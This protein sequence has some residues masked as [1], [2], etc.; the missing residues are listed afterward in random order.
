M[1][2]RV[3]PVIASA[4]P[5]LVKL[6]QET[7]NSWEQ[8]EEGFDEMMGYGGICHLIADEIAGELSKLGLDATT[9]NSQIGENH[10][11]AVVRIGEPNEDPDAPRGEYDGVWSIDIPPGVYES[12]GGYTWKKKRGVEFDASDID[13]THESFDPADFDRYMED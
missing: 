3:P 4:L 8:D 12:G 10:V 6:A 2:R 7:Y 11:W 1:S 13:V 9:I 5:T